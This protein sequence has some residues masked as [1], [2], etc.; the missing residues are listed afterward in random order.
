MESFTLRAMVDG[1]LAVARS[2]RG[3]AP[4]SQPDLETERRLI[5]EGLA[6]DAEIAEREAA[7]RAEMEE[8]A[9]LHEAA[10]HKA[11]A[12]AAAAAAQPPPMTLARVKAALLRRIRAAVG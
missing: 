6:R 11:E 5:A 1:H 7:I 12:A 9:R 8:K 10:I 2:S 3:V 4:A